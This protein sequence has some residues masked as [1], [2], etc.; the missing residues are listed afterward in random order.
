[1]NIRKA[2]IIGQV[3]RRNRLLKHVNEGKIRGKDI[4]YGKTKE[5]T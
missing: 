3:L 5:K 1:V 2:N 4:G